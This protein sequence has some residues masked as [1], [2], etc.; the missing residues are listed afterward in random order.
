[1]GE[2]LVNGSR[3]TAAAG[4]SGAVVITAVSVAAGL[5]Y[6]GQQ[7]EAYAPLTHFI[8]ELGEPGVSVLAPVF[9]V[10]LMVGGACLA[11]FMIGLAAHLPGFYRYGVAVFGAVAGV[12]GALVGVFPMDRRDLHGLVALTFFQTAW[13]AV[14]LFTLYVLVRGP[15]RFPRW[16]AI[17]GAAT[18]LAFVGFLLDVRI[19][20]A[21][22]GAAFVT[23][24]VRPDPWAMPTLEWATLVTIVVWVALV[25]TRL[26]VTERETSGTG[27]AEGSRA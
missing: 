16:L 20:T 2:R 7:G 19:E 15:D 9:D 1:V 11:V 21:A 27:V 18:V 24:A 14:G 26:W 8:S 25:A 6:V 12:A 5:V 3:L 13:I 22:G 4:W 23:P 10:G 17:P